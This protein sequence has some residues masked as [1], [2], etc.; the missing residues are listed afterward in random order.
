MEK[1]EAIKTEKVPVFRT[2]VGTFNPDLRMQHDRYD[3][4]YVHVQGI[5]VYTDVL[6]F[7]DR[8][9]SLKNCFTQEQCSSFYRLL[10]R[11]AA[12]TW[13]TSLHAEERQHLITQ[14]VDEFCKI[15]T[16]AWLSEKEDLERIFR[17]T[18]NDMYTRKDVPL[19]PLLYRHLL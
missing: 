13:W 1:Q 15:V 12:G 10:L 17:F 9:R 5:T 8:L 14:D 2:D 11:G 3:I 4:G 16:N 19:G 18:Y 7:S 6:V